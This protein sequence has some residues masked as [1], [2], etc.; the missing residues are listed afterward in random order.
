M[1]RT[2]TLLIS[3]AKVSLAGNSII[4]TIV[5]AY[6]LAHAQGVRFGLVAL[7]GPMTNFSWFSPL[8]RVFPTYATLE[9]ALPES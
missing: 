9:Q 1:G 2:Q 5:E 8:D 6:Q 7:N 3:F 4:A